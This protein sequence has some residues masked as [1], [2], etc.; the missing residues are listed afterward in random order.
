MNRILIDTDVIL[1]VF[2][3]REPFLKHSLQIIQLC[4]SKKIKGY[5][6]PV[7][8]SNLYYLLR[9]NFQHDLVI[10]Y[11]KQ[12]YTITDLIVITKT[13]LH[14]AL[15]SEIKDFEDA[16]QVFSCLQHNKIDA[17]IT[18]NVKDFKKS[19]IAAMTPETYLN[20]NQVQ[21]T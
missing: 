5:L 10:S 8:Y 15:N 1:D 17:I 9:R 6:T 3:R 2:K 19:S 11:L 12:L 18:R 4:E 20:S 21:L 7:I 13:S 16:L 14:S